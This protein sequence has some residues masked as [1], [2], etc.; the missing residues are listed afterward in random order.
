MTD[1][2]V[3]IREIAQQWGLDTGVART[4]VFEE[5]GKIKGPSPR[6][7]PSGRRVLGLT[8]KQLAKA[9][10]TREAFYKAKAAKTPKPPAR[11]PVTAA[12]FRKIR[13]AALDNGFMDLGHI[14]REW[15][16]K[17]SEVLEQIHFLDPTLKDC[18]NLIPTGIESRNI[19]AK[20]RCGLYQDEFD[21]LTAIGK[22]RQAD[23]EADQ[24]ARN[25]L[26]DAEVERLRAEKVRYGQARVEATEAWDNR[27]KAANAPIEACWAEYHSKVKASRATRNAKIEVAEAAYD[28]YVVPLTLALR[29]KV[30]ALGE[31]PLSG[32]RFSKEAEIWWTYTHAR[33]ALSLV[34]GN[35]VGVH[36]DERREA[37]EDARHLHRQ[38]VW[39]WRRELYAA[40]EPLKR[41]AYAIFQE[42]S[43]PVDRADFDLKSR[44]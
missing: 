38:A 41:T 5:L 29:A 27:L 18:A 2:F 31:E 40:I 10:S 44:V 1:T 6:Q 14:G 42:G 3:T 37:K 19:P 39:Q 12:A 21:R 4:A 17:W 9:T 11:K 35:E 34:F 8:A 20:E 16:M 28:E 26:V 32:P 33:N 23:Q 7:H 30:E 25:D 15:G 24:Q 22:Q 43:V 36:K 13:M